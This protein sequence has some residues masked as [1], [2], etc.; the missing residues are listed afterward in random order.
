[1][2]IKPRRRETAI[3]EGKKPLMTIG[4]WG[5]VV[6]FHNGVWGRN[7]RH[8]EHFKP[9]WITYWDPV[10]GPSIK[11]VTLFLANFD[12][13]SPCHTLSHISGPPKVCDTSRNPP[14]FNSTCIHTYICLYRR[15]VLVCGV[16]VRKV[17]SGL[18]FVRPL[19]CQ[20]TSVTT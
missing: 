11:Y 4:A 12:S 15:F 5:S 8:F 19:F 2:G 20:N 18:A 7:R 17:L 10:K 14:I 1:M 13:P 16:F 6:S 9:K 3:A